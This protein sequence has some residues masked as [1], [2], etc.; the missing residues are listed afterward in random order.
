MTPT[1]DNNS[2]AAIIRVSEDPLKPRLV[3]GP[4]KLTC[5]QVYNVADE[6]DHRGMLEVLYRD[7]DG[8]PL[9]AWIKDK[10]VAYVEDGW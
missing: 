7:G 6:L 10:R 3:S 5:K 9:T 1:L 8:A 2:A 4:Q